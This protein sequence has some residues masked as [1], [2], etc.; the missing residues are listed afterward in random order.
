MRQTEL[1]LSPADRAAAEGVRAGGT[2][3]AREVNRAHILL[4]L[5]RRVPEAQIVAVL[6][7]RRMM[8]WR[9]RRAY[10]DGGLALALRDV[11]RPGRPR[12][13]GTDTEARVAALAC[14]QAPAG[15]ARWTVRLLHEAVLA[16]AGL[17]H[18]SRETVRRLLKKTASSLGAS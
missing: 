14:S 18:I 6:G 5:D 4:A 1:K 7:I 2:R 11:Q 17:P 16:E 3:P 12:K 9:T 10:M 13:C 15:S 8:I